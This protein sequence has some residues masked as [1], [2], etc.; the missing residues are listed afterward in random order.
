MRR[1]IRRVKILLVSEGLIT[2]AIYARELTSGLKRDG[3]FDELLVNLV[4]A[5]SYLTL[6]W[7]NFTP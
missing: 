4:I 5:F 2:V 1:L 7:L 6:T 3:F